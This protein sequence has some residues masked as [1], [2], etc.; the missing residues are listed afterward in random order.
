MLGCL[1][2]KDGY[3]SD[4]AQ[5]KRGVLTLKYQVEHSIVTNSGD[6]DKICYHTFHSDTEAQKE[7]D[8]EFFDETKKACTAKNEEWV[9]RKKLREN[10]IAG[11][12]E[13]LKI[14]TGDEAR[15]LFA[16]AIKPGKDRWKP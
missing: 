11:M 1:D 7:A 6:M 3:G 16:D 2:Q 10:E 8:I 4:E 15:K 13:A 9:V 14:L 12:K 5:S